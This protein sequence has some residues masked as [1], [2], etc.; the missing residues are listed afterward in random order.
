MENDKKTD[1][2]TGIYFLRR[3]LWP[4]LLASKRANVVLFIRGHIT[5]ALTRTQ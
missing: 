5:N 2:Q 1:L 3:E 4:V